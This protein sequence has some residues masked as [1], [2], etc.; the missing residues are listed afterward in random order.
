MLVDSCTQAEVSNSEV[1]QLE[2]NCELF[3]VELDID[4]YNLK[5]GWTLKL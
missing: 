4:R 1:L 5:S 2:M 3:L